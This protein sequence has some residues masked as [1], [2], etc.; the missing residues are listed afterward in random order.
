MMSM[1]PSIF[2]RDEKLITQLVVKFGVSHDW[3][4]FPRILANHGLWNKPFFV[5]EAFIF[6]SQFIQPPTG[7][8]KNL[9][10]IRNPEIK[11]HFPPQEKNSLRASLRGKKNIIFPKQIPLIRLAISLVGNVAL[12]ETMGTWNFCMKFEI[13][14]GPRNGSL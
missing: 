9:F 6:H 3:F 4:R 10:S 8:C 13:R 5:T 12:G 7:L 14:F 1:F 11:S 2:R